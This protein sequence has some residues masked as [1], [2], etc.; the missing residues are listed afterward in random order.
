MKLRAAFLMALLPGVV[1]AADP[2]AGEL[3]IHGSLRSRMEAWGW[4][5]GE[6][7]GNYAFLGNL[8]RVDFGQRREKFEWKVELAAPALLGLPRDAVAPGAQGQLG[9]GANYYVA[10]GGRRNTAMVFPKQAYIRWRGAG[11]QSV[12]LG[13]FEFSDGA[14]VVPKNPTLA[15][16]KNTRIQQRLLGPFGFTH[17][18]RSY[19]GLHYAYDAGGNNFT[20][21]G[22]V[23]TR[24]VFQTDGW[25]W[26]NV[27][28]AYG[29]WT[30]QL[31]M[32]GGAGDLRI[33]G[34]YYDDWRPIAKTDNRPAAARARDLANVRIGSFGGHYLHAQA[35][36]AGTVD[37]LAWGVGQTGR[38]GALDHRGSAAAL[39]AGFQ[40]RGLKTLKP[41]FRGGYFYAS[42]DGDPGDNR[43][44]TFFGILPTP[45]IYARFP[46]FNLMNI[47]DAFAEVILRPH[48]KVSIRADVHG[49]RLAESRDLWY[50]GGGAFNPWSFGYVGRAAS[51][52]SG[53]ATLYDLSADWAA[54]AQVT[55]GAYYGFARGQSAMRSIY[56]RGGNAQYGYV[57]VT[58]RF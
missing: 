12:R 55:V 44:G 51:G 34:I 27:G 54:T 4:F 21:V 5:Q 41:W 20:F 40:P 42:G 8:L 3:S 19:D 25:G 47:R 10:N 9:M 16:L 22:A 37:L 57:E 7:D 50:L 23:P 26:A 46:F 31:S 33:F 29:A 56:P 58:W 15:A 24:G 32:G 38:W 2:A 6:A 45:R 35:T 17:V 14:E 39:E 53:L 1:A 30:R 52:R 48:G 11:G 43:H 36:G 18:G 13:R 49:L 28:V